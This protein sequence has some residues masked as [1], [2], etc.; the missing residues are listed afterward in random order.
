MDETESSEFISWEWLEYFISG[1]AELESGDKCI[2]IYV[3]QHTADQT[4]VLAMR[5][6]EAK[7]MLRDVAWSL[8]WLGDEKAKKVMEVLDG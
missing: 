7:K 6:D 4:A 1:P 5:D 3:Y 8:A 2:T